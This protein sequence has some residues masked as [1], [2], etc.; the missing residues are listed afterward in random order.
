MCNLSEGIWEAALLEGKA[1]GEAKA[2]ANMIL[3]MRQKGFTPKEI[4]NIL[5]KEEAEVEAVLS[6]KEIVSV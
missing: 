2:L 1:E 4:A 3:Q 5:D 6:G